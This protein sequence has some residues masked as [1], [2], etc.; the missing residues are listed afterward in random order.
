[1]YVSKLIGKKTIISK[2]FFLNSKDEFVA[3][4]DLSIL[5]KENLI[6]KRSEIIVTYA[7]CG[8]SNL[9]S[10]G[11]QLGGLGIMAPNR[12]EDLTKIAFRSLI[13]GTIACFLTANIAGLYL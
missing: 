3:Y 2:L 7:L 5:I 9:S 10:I 12:I 8:F 6:S 1:L 11:V 4:S 13:S